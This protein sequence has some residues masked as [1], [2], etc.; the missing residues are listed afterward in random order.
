MAPIPH[1]ISNLYWKMILKGPTAF[2]IFT[3]ESNFVNVLR[4]NCRPEHSCTGPSDNREAQPRG[5]RCE[6][7][8]HQTK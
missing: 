5:K 2:T 7:D 3:L 6:G 1:P 4:P 8:N